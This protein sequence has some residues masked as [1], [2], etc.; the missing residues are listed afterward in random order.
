MRLAYCICEVDSRRLSIY[1][2]NLDVFSVRIFSIRGSF[3]IENASD[4]EREKQPTKPAT[5]GTARG[6][7]PAQKT[8]ELRRFQIRP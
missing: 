7:W 8:R 6:N 5:E 2:F 4:K 3:L 1:P